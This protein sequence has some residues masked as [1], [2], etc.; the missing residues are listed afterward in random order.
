MSDKGQILIGTSGW[1]Y[2]HWKGTFYPSDLSS[3]SM[4]AYYHEQQL[5]TAEINNTFYQLPEKKT[6]QSWKNT[7]PDQFTFS[8][9][10]SRYITHMKKL[11]EPQQSLNKFLEQISSL[12]PQLGPILFQLSPQWSCNFQRLQSFL[13]LLPDQFRYTFEFRNESWFSEEIYEL[14]ADHETALCISDLDGELTPI[15][16]TTD[17]SYLR[18]HGPKKRYKGRYSSSQLQQWRDRF[19]TWSAENNRDI[20]CYFDNDQRGYAANNAI[21]LAEL[22]KEL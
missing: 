2:D 21:E 7:V 4:L 20:Y 11:N 17:F 18:L 13:D 9:K 19:H 8:V 15:R 6:L 12:Q 1:H 3:D 10:A 14:L 16:H 5:Q 22:C